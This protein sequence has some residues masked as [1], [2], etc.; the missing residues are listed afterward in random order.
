MGPLA[1]A[2]AHQADRPE[3]TEGRL[4]TRRGEE[5]V[6]VPLAHTRV[7]IHVAGHLAEAELTQ[8]FQNPYDEPIEAVYLFPLPT[9]AA[10]QSLEMKIGERTITGAIHRRVKAERI[11]QRARSQGRAATLLTQERPNLF[12]QSVANIAPG[13]RVEVT[14][15]YAHAL[16]YERGGYELVFP[17]VAGPRYLPGGARDESIQPAV[18]GPGRRPAHDIDLA[19]ELDAG[20]PIEKLQSPSH[21]IKWVGVGAH[22]SAR[23]APSDTIPNKDFIL[24]Y[25]V[26]GDAPRFALMPHRA[27][28]DQPGSFFLVAQ[29]PASTEEVAPRELIFALDTSSSMAGAPLAQ[30]KQVIRRVLT[31]MRADDTFQIVR[32]ADRAS[33]LGPGPI[34][35]KPDN[36]QYTLDW[37]DAID[38]HG[39]TE[40]A[41][42]IDAALALPHDPARVRIVV[43][44]SD[45]YIGNEE[46]IL[47]QVTADMGDARL[48]GF[49]VGSAVNRYLLEEMAAAG[50]GDVQFVRPDEDTAAAVTRFYERIDAPILTDIAIDWGGLAVRDVVPARVPDLFAGQ[51][52][53]IAGH[54]ATAGDGAV[55]I[56]GRQ[57][58][59]A[60][61][62]EVPV[63]LPELAPSH[64]SI[65]A[66]WARHRIRELSRQHLRDRDPAGAEAITQL[67]LEHGLMSRYTAFVAVDSATLADPSADAP[68]QVRVPVE[69][70]QAVRGLQLYSGG[71]EGSFG[72]IGYGVGGGVAYG[73][74]GYGVSSGTIQRRDAEVPQVRIGTA[75]VLGSLDKNIIRRYIRRHHSKLRYCYEKSL[76]TAPELSG[77]VTSEFIINNTGEVTDVSVSGIGDAALHECV[78]TT[79]ASIAFPKV[80]NGDLVRVRYPFTMQKSP[81]S[82]QSQPAANEGGDNQ[83]Q[84]QPAG[85]H[86]LDGREESAP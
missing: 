9:G 48:F 7:R 65:A 69:V 27:R 53:V 33:A 8:V 52:L 29:P 80:P 35:N 43:F 23:I 54:Y 55:T 28:A 30:A 74:V 86:N 61:Q 83:P 36:I 13:A 41:R 62:F 26:A 20:V 56:R 34:A 66:V 59:R 15:Q 85:R 47:A 40:L 32:F 21:D 46:H 49:G 19:V 76:R 70:P 71:V 51:P 16:S 1:S 64:A 79:V 25:Q 44:L 67:A 22:A 24:R 45:G 4:V 84:Q 3:P 18:L 37:L 78:R 5:L 68:K 73:A 10:V 11:Y 58:G 42:G 12:T 57:G 50:R 72:T 2:Q 6:E 31:G 82:Q 14:M 81:E 39:G 63:A 17:M 38:A 77:V 75:T 60:V